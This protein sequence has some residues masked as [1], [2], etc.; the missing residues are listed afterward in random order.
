MET[1]ADRVERLTDEISRVVVGQRGRI[2]GLLIA[3]L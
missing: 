3:L 2:D 1:A